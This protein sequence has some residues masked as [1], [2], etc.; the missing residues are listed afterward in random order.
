MAREAEAGAVALLRFTGAPSLRPM[1]ATETAAHLAAARD[2]V[3]EVEA[4]RSVAAYLSMAAAGGAEE[5]PAEPATL[6][7]LADG[8]KGYMVGIGK[9]EPV[10]QTLGRL[11]EVFP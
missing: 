7:R 1:R 6:R 3:K 9:G 8:V 5:D 2:L 10:E 11:G 4:Y